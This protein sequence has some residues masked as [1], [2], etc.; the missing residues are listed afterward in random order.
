MG[1]GHG[2]VQVDELA[3]S[4]CAFL[5]SRRKAQVARGSSLL[6]RVILIENL[7]PSKMGVKGCFGPWPQHAA[8]RSLSRGHGIAATAR[9]L[10][11]IPAPN[12]R[13]T[14]DACRRASERIAQSGSSIAPVGFISVGRHR[15]AIAQ[16]LAGRVT[17]SRTL[18]RAFGAHAAWIISPSGFASTDANVLR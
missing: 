1:L 3:A 17:Q 14:Q 4:Q 8:V 18:L 11:H 9:T 5:S 6:Q 16:A 10:W 7:L 12:D 13:L 15:P 2:E